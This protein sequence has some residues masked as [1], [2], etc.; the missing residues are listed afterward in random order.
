MQ[1]KVEATYTPTGQVCVYGPFPVDE[2]T[3]MAMRHLAFAQGF[4][5]GH[6]SHNNPDA[7]PTEWDW[8]VFEIAEE[9]DAPV[10]KVLGKL[11]AEASASVT[12]ADGTTD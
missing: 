4:I 10:V 9:G 2:D 6:F 5:T 3:D 7:L 11:I 8:K 1:R 12:H